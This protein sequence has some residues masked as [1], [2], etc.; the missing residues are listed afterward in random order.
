MLISY[1]KWK[2]CVL[3]N[4]LLN[5]FVLCT[6]QVIGCDDVD[7]KKVGSQEVNV[8]VVCKGGVVQHK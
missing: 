6:D 4:L 8:V 5:L 3:Y 1:I 7:K 2:T